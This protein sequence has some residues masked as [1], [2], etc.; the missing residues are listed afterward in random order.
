MEALFGIVVVVP[1]CGHDKHSTLEVY[2]SPWHRSPLHNLSPVNFKIRILYVLGPK[3]F[4]KK[5][6]LI[7]RPA[8]SGHV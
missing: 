6:L 8:I 5:A 1:N 7:F 3:L 4:R 2:Y